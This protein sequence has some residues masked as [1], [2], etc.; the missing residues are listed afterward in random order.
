MLR[1]WHFNCK[2]LVNKQTATLPYKC[3]LNVNVGLSQRKYFAYPYFQKLELIRNESISSKALIYY[4]YM[5]WLRI[6][7]S[8][9]L[10]FKLEVDINYIKNMYQA[11]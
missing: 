5:K 2:T 1:K 4:V 6:I 3:I 10:D 11:Y 7:R 8:S 9:T